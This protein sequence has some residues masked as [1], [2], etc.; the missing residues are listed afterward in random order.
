MA[1]DS[2]SHCTVF[3]STVG[4]T[5]NCKRCWIKMSTEVFPYFQ[6]QDYY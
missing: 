5:V 2:L 3:L 4:T 6:L 1:K